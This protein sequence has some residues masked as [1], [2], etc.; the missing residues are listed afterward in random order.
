MS[1]SR[2]QKRDYGGGD[3]EEE[4]MIGARTKD[5]AMKD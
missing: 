4:G 2:A 5:A 3:R 1:I